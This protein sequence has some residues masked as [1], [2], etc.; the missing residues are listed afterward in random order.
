MAPDRSHRPWAL[1]LVGLALAAAGGTSVAAQNVDHDRRSLLAGVA[2]LHVVR[3]GGDTDI[4]AGIIVGVER[5]RVYLLTALHVVVG[6]EEQRRRSGWERDPGRIRIGVQFFGDPLSVSG[7]LFGRWREETDLA[8]VVVDDPRILDR[9]L[10]VSFGVGSART[11]SPPYPA[12]ALGHGGSR[13]WAIL[14]T[15]VTSTTSDRIAFAGSDIEPGHSGGALLDTTRRL[16]VGMITASSRGV[17]G[18]ALAT[19]AIITDLESWGIP[20]H[21]RAARISTPMVRVPAGTFLMGEGNDSG[22]P[23]REIFLSTYFIDK[24]EVTVRDFR[25]FV[26]ESGHAYQAGVS[27]CNYATPGR[28]ALPMNCVSWDDAAAFAAWAGK[29][30]PTEAQ[31]EKAAR[32]PAGLPFPGGRQPL[33]RGEVALQLE[34]PGA[35]VGT[36]PRDRSVY[37]AMDMLGGVSEWV[38]DWYQRRH[39]LL[40]ASRNPPGPATGQDR[41]L[42]G[43]SFESSLARTDLRLRRR[44]LPES[45]RLRFDYGFRCVLD[46]G[47]G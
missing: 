5:T 4:G 17:G 45:G 16:L 14:A 39:L 40:L 26:E 21:L 34:L 37:G 38:A 2:R 42:R 41:V 36:H 28:D 24:H 30:L 43:G 29:R 10:A 20:H 9:G 46:E 25:R 18:E 7:T 47:G 32:G 6:P 33:A 31:W 22:D 11:L 19:D 15:R 13:D 3:P 44:D 8:V 23:P 12:L 35:A 27:T 1:A